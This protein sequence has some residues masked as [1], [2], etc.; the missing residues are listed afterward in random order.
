MKLSE[1]ARSKLK[2]ILSEEGKSIGLR[3]GVM[4][5]G[6]S[7]FQ[8][9]MGLIEKAEEDDTIFEEILFVDPISLGYLSDSTVDFVADGLNQQFTIQNPQVKAT[10]GCGSSFDV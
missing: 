8:Y 6:C 10:C 9:T 2:E 7:G 3:V 1:K 4:G 5:G